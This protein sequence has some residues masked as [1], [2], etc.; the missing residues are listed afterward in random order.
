M[1]TVIR[2]SLETVSL[3]VLTGV[4]GQGKPTYA[5]AVN[6]QART[7]RE[8]MMVKLG[9]GSEVRTS[10]TLWFEASTSPMPGEQDRL[11]L[12]DGLKGIVVEVM[13]GKALGGKI[14]HVRLKIREE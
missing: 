4:D 8:D 9:N 6:V 13:V 5:T 12:L 2:R 11:T 14:D 1:S 3:E 7:V 10:A